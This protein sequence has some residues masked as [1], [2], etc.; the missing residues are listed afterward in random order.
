MLEA[1]A[2]STAVSSSGLQS[3]RAL[4]DKAAVGLCSGTQGEQIVLQPASE[5]LSGSSRA[6]SPLQPKDIPEELPLHQ[7][8]HKLIQ[9]LN[10]FSGGFCSA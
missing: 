6:H 9:Q 10:I 7:C 3:H 1:K 5:F 4:C 8:P 2:D